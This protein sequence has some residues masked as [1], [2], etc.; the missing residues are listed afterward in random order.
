MREYNRIK[1]TAKKMLAFAAAG[2]VLFAG[3]PVQLAEASE[4]TVYVS[5]FGNGENTGN[6]KEN[7]LSS[8][9]AAV[10]KLPDGGTIVVTDTV[11]IS[12]EVSYFLPDG[13]VL[14]ASEELSGPVFEVTEGAAL[15]LNKIVID[16]KKDTLISN[17]GTLKISGEVSL[18]KD[19]ST[20]AAE[21]AVDTAK[22]AATWK[23]DVLIEGTDTSAKETESGTEETENRIK[24]TETVRKELES[25]T[26]SSENGVYEPENSAKDTGVTTEETESAAAETEAEGK[27]TEGGN[28]ESSSKDSQTGV[29]E[30]KK[31]EKA[32]EGEKRETD[33]DSGKTKNTLSESEKPG[34]E[35]SETE[36][37]VSD[38]TERT[39]TEE[40]TA[41][42]TFSEDLN[43]ASKEPEIVFLYAV[44]QVEA[45]IGSI[46]VNSREDIAAVVEVTK[47]YDVLSEA[48][49]QTI[50]QEAKAE[51]TAL[52]E[53]AGALNHTQD[54][55]SVSGNLPW[56]VQFRAEKT[57]AG[58]AK[59]ENFEILAPYELKLWDMYRNKEYKL[60]D[61]QKVRI[62]MPL[63]E[64]ETD[65]N[66]VILHYLKD[67]TAE[68]I[69]PVVCGNNLSFETGSFSPFSVAGST[70]L[71]GIGVTEG[72]PADSPAGAKDGK[73]NTPSTESG[74]FSSSNSNSNNEGS[75]TEVQKSTVNGTVSLAA[76][77]GDAT[78]ILP[79]VIAVLA[80]AAV[81]VGLAITRKKKK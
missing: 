14:K 18:K 62:T 33:S 37:S 45:Q 60:E 81:L 54:G 74:S 23:D 29:K 24:E 65:G 20:L 56:Y 72:E 69:V 43:E 49:K 4:K 42:E 30:N 11:Y 64:R 53:K 32:S 22:G 58:E 50:S 7:P 46:Q 21:Q 27:E 47:T 28:A 35:E 1:G 12:S 10:E 73:E 25:G 68:T 75:S 8:I 67:G 38:K 63:P 79:Y 78:R 19:G 77:T 71:T 66:Y 16:G 15:F 57:D 61:G 36:E 31:E 51:L 41:D 34:T 9:Y 26:G 2:A 59:R 76:A 52:Q 44:K 5:G 13:I 48:E 17:Y 40:K 70:V 80:A 55:I 3:I 6:T 39:E